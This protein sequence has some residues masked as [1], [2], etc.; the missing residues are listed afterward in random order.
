MSFLWHGAL[1]TS[2]PLHHTVYCKGNSLPELIGRIDLGICSLIALCKMFYTEN[3]WCTFH[4]QSNTVLIHHLCWYSQ[5][6]HP[7][8]MRL[9]CTHHWNIWKSAV[10][11]CLCQSLCLWT[12]WRK[13]WKCLLIHLPFVLLHWFF[14]WACPRS[15]RNLR[16]FSTVGNKLE[17]H[18][19][20]QCSSRVLQAKT[21]W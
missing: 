10:A 1:Y 19:L 13:Y 11:D 3:H 5:F 7:A 9:K 8:G 18:W 12:C 6:S 16:P 15:E 21:N 17:I 14:W 4:P 2:C 20:S